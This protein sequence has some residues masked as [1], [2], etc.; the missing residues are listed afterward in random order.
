M[1]L[2]IAIL[3]INGLSMNPWLYL[4]AGFVWCL[5]HLSFIGKT[6]KELAKLNDSWSLQKKRSKS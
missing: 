6:L 4:R 1:T 3:L 2:L 5:R